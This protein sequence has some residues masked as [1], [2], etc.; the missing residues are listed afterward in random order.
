RALQG[1]KTTVMLEGYFNAA[2]LAALKHIPVADEQALI[3]AV[4]AIENNS[5]NRVVVVRRNLDAILKK[6]ED[7]EPK[8]HSEGGTAE[9]LVHAIDQTQE[10]VA[11]FSKIAEAVAL[12]NDQV[13]ALECYRWFGKLFVKYNRPEMLSGRSSDADYDFFKFVGHEL[14][15]TLVAF[16]IREQRWELLGVLVSEQIPMTYVPR[17]HGPG[18]VYWDYASKHLILLMHESKIKGRMSLHADMLHNR[19]TDG[20]LGSVLPFIEFTAADYFLFLLGELPPSDVPVGMPWRPWSCLFMKKT[21]AFIKSAEQK[22]TARMIINVFGISNVDE[23]K[24]RLNGRVGK[25][26][27][28]FRDGWWDQPV[29]REDIDRIGT[30]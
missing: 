20:G 5:G 27:Q 15:V 23:F 17:E 12:M 4:T 10:V 28:L 9:E 6:I 14:F 24:K 11:E 1:K 2:I 16:L 22:K 13:S 21:P 8:K 3:P 25:V 18:N 29:Q 30:R 26:G 7:L 19:H